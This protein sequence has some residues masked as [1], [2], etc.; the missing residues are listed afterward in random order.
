MFLIT[1]SLVPFECWESL[2]Y[3]EYTENERECLRLVMYSIFLHGKKVFGCNLG[4]TLLNFMTLALNITVY[5]HSVALVNGMHFAH[6]NQ[7]FTGSLFPSL[8]I[9]LCT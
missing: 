3:R 5:D 4:Q 6:S 9:H 8:Y 2:L 1:F 7:S